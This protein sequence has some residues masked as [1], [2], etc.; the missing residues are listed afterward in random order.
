[1]QPLI[2]CVDDYLRRK[3]WEE[4]TADCQGAIIRRLMI[5]SGA[6]SC[7]IPLYSD[8]YKKEP[9]KMSTEDIKNRILERLK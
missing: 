7:D 5:M 4:Y 1:M 2:Y 9:E 3:V 6:E 8:L